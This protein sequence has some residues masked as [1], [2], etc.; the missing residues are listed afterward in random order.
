MLRGSEQEC[1]KIRFCLVV[2]EMQSG[3]QLSR[4]P[5]M[6]K[7]TEI[8]NWKRA[9]VARTAR[10]VR[11]RE[12]TIHARL[13]AGV[14]GFADALAR[15]D[16]LAV[17]A[18]IKRKSP[19]AGVIAEA[20]D[21][22]EQA[23][24]YLNAGVDCLSVLTDEK[25]FG[26]TLK[27]L[28]EVTEFIEVHQRT[29]PCLRKDFMVHPVQVLEAAEAGARCILII[30]RALAR[31]EMEDLYRAATLAG[32]D[33]IFEVH[34]L[35]ELEAALPLNPRIIGVNNRDLARFTTDLAI[36]EE[37]LPQVPPGILKI[38][39]SGIFEQGDAR[40]AL[41]AG[42]DAILVGEALM[43]I[44]DPD[45]LEQTVSAFKTPSAR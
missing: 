33:A 28:W 30:V 19:S 32:L 31:G 1:V 17:I 39:E 42:A 7:L 13:R 24:R 12:L 22:E 21:A 18:E 35:E 6:D 20:A 45:L 2:V 27:D 34:T 36:T 29:I 38:S 41:E 11:D 10:P 26:G 43:R 5:C 4:Q 9:E 15:P 25:F 14:P 23:R 40:R 44:E 3:I 8:M 16:A 37:I